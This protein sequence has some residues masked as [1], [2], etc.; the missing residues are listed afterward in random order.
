MPLLKRSWSRQKGVLTDAPLLTVE[1]DSEFDV[2]KLPV[3][4]RQRG[5]QT[6]QTFSANRE[7]FRMAARMKCHP[8]FTWLS[9]KNGAFG[10]CL[11]AAVGLDTQWGNYSGS[12][13]LSNIKQHT[14]SAQHVNA[15]QMLGDP[16]T[17]SV[18]KA[19]SKS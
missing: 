6:W 3:A 8:R 11:C 19:P 10:C 17:P 18:Y 15:E 13:K 1:P 12:L 14:V 9:Y 4:E 5:Q 2:D 16:T 7:R